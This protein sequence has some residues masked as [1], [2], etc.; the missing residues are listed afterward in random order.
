[1]VFGGCWLLFLQIEWYEKMVTK[2]QQSSRSLRTW[3]CSG[4]VCV[5]RL[6]RALV[7]KHNT[8]LQP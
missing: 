7:D 2:E 5:S 3:F 1:M 6:R 8:C 4:S